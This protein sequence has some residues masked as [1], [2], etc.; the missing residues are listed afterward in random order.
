MT[1]HFDPTGAACETVRLSELPGERRDRLLTAYERDV[2]GPAFPDASIRE[3]PSYWSGLLDADPYP[4]PPQP[5]IDVAMLL[6]A[7]GQPI[8]G[9]TIEYYRTARCGLLTYL[10]VAPQQRGRGLGRKLVGLACEILDRLAGGDVPMLAE[11]ERLEDAAD[12][13]E[14]AE[15]DKRQRRLAALGARWIVFDYVMPALRPDSEPHRLHLIV[16]DP[17]K[18]LDTISATRVAALIRELADALGADLAASPD[19]QAMMDFLEDA[20][21]LPVAPLPAITGA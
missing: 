21:E 2:Y 19:T 5:L 3:D 11:T 10:T 9:A 8:G 6:D 15:T 17:A 1:Q 16:F 20:G 12:E 4:P 18:R 14:A 13:S 7:E